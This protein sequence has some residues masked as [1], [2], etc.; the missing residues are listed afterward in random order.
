MKER[1]MNSRFQQLLTKYGTILAL[2]IVTLMFSLFVPGFVNSRNL[3]NILRQVALLAVIAEGFTMCLIVDEL[4]LSFANVASL[5]SVIAG[6]L[7]LG[8]MH[9]F[10]A[11]VIVLAVGA[12][13]GLLNGL[14]VTKVGIPSLITTL[15]MGIISV[16]FIYMFTDGLSLY[17]AM[18][19]GFLFLGRGSIAGI[20]FLVIIMFA[21]VLLAHVLV[22]KFKVGKYMQATGANVRAAR[23]AGINTDFYKI[24]GLVLSSAGAALTG[25]LLTSRLGTANPE[26][27]TGFMM[28]SFASALMG[29]T[30]LSIGR[31]KPLGTLVGVL[32]IGVISNGMTLAGAPYYMQDITKGVIILLSVTITSLQSKRQADA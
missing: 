17:G 8:G 9:P 23:L 31:A 30:V 22:N 13:I 25:I 28:D 19:A 16:G 14:L 18:P 21:V 2:V 3:L 26:G 24:L 32:M 12:G 6:A 15:A 11:I 5:A 10:L 4:D 27:A 29:M 7:I 1:A 20:P